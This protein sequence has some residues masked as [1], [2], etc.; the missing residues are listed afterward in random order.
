MPTEPDVA[1]FHHP[2]SVAVFGASENTDKIGGRP[3]FYMKQFGFAGTVYPINPN[4]DTVQ[5]LPAYPNLAALPEAPDVAV[6]AVS[7]RG[8]LDAVAQCAEAGVKGAV[9]MSSGFGETRDPEGNAMQAEMVR[10]ARASGLRLVGP[11][12]QGLSDFGTGAIL[13]FSTMFIEAP[14][15]DGPVAIVSQSG[16]MSAIPYGLLRERGVGL[17]YVHG[18]G[19]DA[20]A[21][22]ADLLEAVVN[23]PDIKVALLY[24]EGVAD[25]A[26]LERAA[27]VA[28]ERGVPV[29]ALVGGRTTAGARAAQSHTGALASEGR[30]VEAL[31][32]RLGIRQVSSMNDFVQ[33]VDLYL[34]GA[35]VSGDRLAIMS[36]SGGVCVLASDYASDFGL[37]L[38]TFDAPTEAAIAAALPS[39]ASPRNPIDITAGLLSDS[40]LIRRALDAIDNS[41]GADAFLVS[42][43]VAGRGYDV[44]EFGSAIADFSAR[45]NRPVVAITPQPSV[46]EVFRKRGL[47][48]YVDEADGVRAIAG[49]VRHHALIERASKSQ[50]LDLRRAS[51]Q[52][53]TMLNEA[54]SLA[55]LNGRADVVAHRLVVGAAE[56]ASAFAEFSGGRVVVKGCTTSVS[57]KSEHGLVEL[58]CANEAETAEAATRI[59]AAMAEHGFRNE[60]LLVE[61]MLDGAF[62]VMVGGHRDASLG[63]VVIV[64]AGGRYVEAVPDF[65][66]LLPPFGRSEV[67]EA[68]RGLRMAPLLDGVRGEAAVDINAWVELAVAVGDLLVAPDSSIESFDANP[69]LLVRAGGHTR[70]VVADAVVVTNGG[71]VE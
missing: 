21:N 45:I 10:L 23:D 49:Y 15:Q 26:G 46:T 24:L 44:E 62:E 61:E 27:R 57:H 65:A 69:V 39:F 66:M 18:T 11:N 43:P 4:R 68:I 42:I 47:S 58:G 70:A 63:A 19:N 50:L 32:S 7:G 41:S 8:A 29:V 54:Q 16:G 14:P 60:G 37:P 34:V 48:V 20:D 25:P 2:A 1:I 5:G 30:V 64:G 40:G 55:C 35:E 33:S 12:S 51:D 71:R 56:A 53:T 59:V 67:S 38:A 17:R 31:L 3:I 28:L 6:I 52:P 36:N 13:S 22:V 9:I